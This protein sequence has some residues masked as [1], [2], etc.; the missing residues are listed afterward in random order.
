MLFR[1]RD[2]INDFS[3]LDDSLS[4]VIMMDFSYPLN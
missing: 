1:G 4:A 2:I 3:K